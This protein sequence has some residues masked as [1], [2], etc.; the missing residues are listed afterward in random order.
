M[1]GLVICGVIMGIVSELPLL[2][3][4]YEELKRK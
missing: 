2:I 4:F 1:V 3:I